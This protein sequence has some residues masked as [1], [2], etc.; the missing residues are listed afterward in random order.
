MVTESFFQLIGRQ[1]GYVNITRSSEVP[2]E[3]MRA[4]TIGKR[5]LLV[6]NIGGRFFVADR[7]CPHF[8][9]NLCLGKLEGEAVMCP[10]HRARFDLNTGDVLRDPHILF[11][12]LGIRNG[13]RTYPTQVEGDQVMSDLGDS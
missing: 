4:V 10:L 3:E 13:L 1:M 9:V 12:N 7:K 2:P 5:K 11:L 6:A 8:G